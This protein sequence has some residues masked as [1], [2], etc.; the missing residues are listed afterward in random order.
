[1]REGEQFWGGNGSGFSALVLRWGCV[2]R[3]RYF[4]VASDARGVMR[5][6]VIIKMR[7]GGRHGSKDS[8]K[9]RRK[10]AKRQ[11]KKE[12]SINC[13]NPNPNRNTELDSGTQKDL[14]KK[15]ESAEKEG[16]YQTARERVKKS[17]TGQKS[18]KLLLKDADDIAL[19]VRG[20]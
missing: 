11:G 10:I 18:P 7:L 19:G 2:A 1:M 15:N 14:G 8:S 6:A 13:A 20:S 16:E 3:G 5:K 4:V 9:N 12:K 17:G